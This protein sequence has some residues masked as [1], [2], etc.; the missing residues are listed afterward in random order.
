MSLIGCFG[1]FW[2]FALLSDFQTLIDSTEEISKQGKGQ[3]FGFALAKIL[4]PPLFIFSPLIFIRI[5][6]YVTGL[7]FEQPASRATWIENVEFLRSTPVYILIFY[8]LPVLTYIIVVNVFADAPED[9]GLLHWICFFHFYVSV[10]PLV[11]MIPGRKN[12]DY[13]SIFSR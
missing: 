11:W 8:G 5:A 4:L 2:V 12:I 9:F 3:L 7:N 6:Q 10:F 1:F 13:M